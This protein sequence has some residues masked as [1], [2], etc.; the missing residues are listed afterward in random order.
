[1]LRSGQGHLRLQESR[2]TYSSLCRHSGPVEESSESTQIE[3]KQTNKHITE[4]KV[5]ELAHSVTDEQPNLHTA[6]E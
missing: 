1:M 6:T 3:K 5:T 2:M 4:I